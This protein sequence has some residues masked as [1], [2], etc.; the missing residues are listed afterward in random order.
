MTDNRRYLPPSPSPDNL[1]KQA[2]ARLATLR[3]HAPST[4][5]AEVQHLIAREYGFTNWKELQ[6]EVARRRE[7]QSIRYR[8]FRRHRLGI[9][10]QSQD[11][12]GPH[13]LDHML[14]AAASAAIFCIMAGVGGGLMYLSRWPQADEL[15]GLRYGLT[16]LHKFL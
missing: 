12:D 13:I 11:G 10:E 8:K 1:R 2:K 3:R 16:L 5:L 4:R 9:P 15:S 6:A 14:T 7:N